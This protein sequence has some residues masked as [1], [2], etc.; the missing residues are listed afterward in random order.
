ME[1]VCN[2]NLPRPD[3]LVSL[4]AE[5]TVGNISPERPSGSGASVPPGTPPGSGSRIARGAFERFTR[6]QHPRR[7]GAGRREGLT[8][9]V[10]DQQ[11]TRR[12]L[13][14]AFVV[15]LEPGRGQRK[16]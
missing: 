15:A 10:D 7:H 8:S 11:V 14:G 3:R 13:F 12:G 1:V 5:K 16:E 2:A 9:A 6:W 4:Q